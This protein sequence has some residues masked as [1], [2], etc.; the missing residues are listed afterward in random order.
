MAVSASC[1]GRRHTCFLV[2][3]ALVVLVYFILRSA[4][5]ISGNSGS[6]KQTKAH[7]HQ[8]AEVK[9]DAGGRPEQTATAVQRARHQNRFGYVLAS[10]YFDQITGSM[11]NYMSMQCWAGT[12][13]SRVKV[14]E[15]FIL[16]S[17]FGMNTS[18]MSERF[19]PNATNLTKLG[20]LFDRREWIR[21]TSQSSELAP[22]FGWNYFIRDA[23][24]KLI[25]VDRG[26][27]DRVE[28]FRKC[29]D[30]IQLIESLK[31]N[32][33]VVAFSWQYGFQIVRKTC[34]PEVLIDARK[35]R[36][37]VYGNFDPRQV[38]V[39]FESWGGIQQNEL[40]IRAPI[41]DI[42]QCGRMN[43][44]YNIPVSQSIKEDGER[45]IKKY[46]PGALTGG[47]VAVMMRMQY[48]AIMNAFDVSSG[49]Y[50]LATL[51]QCFRGIQKRVRSL[52][53]AHQ[54]ILLTLDCRSQGSYF[55]S[56]PNRSKQADIIAQSI[57]EFYQMLMG[58]STTL[59]DWDKSYDDIASFKTPGYIAILQKHLAASSSCLVLAGAG[60]FQLTAETMYD[61]YHNQHA[62]Q[63]CVVNVDINNG[64]T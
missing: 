56:S 62:Q 4:P 43:F 14:V 13:R 16:H 10:S 25:V 7:Q 28:P 45:Y 12:L 21:Q 36:S 18:S 33:S 17:T 63:R 51:N 15:P 31:F 40:D 39:L 41:S 59:E 60:A 6:K 29:D 55:F 50:I 5:S 44:Y 57:P 64:C 23:P 37:L 9:S 30:C 53:Q 54:P 8:S 22:I 3:L 32:E 11:A 52:R 42:T 26:C 34:I 48:I 38:V 58:S 20:D 1:W 19:V 47:Y 24:S 27:I 35:F 46:M 2:V 49:D 61:V